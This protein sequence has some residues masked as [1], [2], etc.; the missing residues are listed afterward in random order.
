MESLEGEDISLSSYSSTSGLTMK[1]RFVDKNS[2]PI[3]DNTATMH[4]RG[5]TDPIKL[6]TY[7]RQNNSGVAAAIDVAAGQMNIDGTISAGNSHGLLVGDTVIG[8]I[9]A[10]GETTSG[11]TV[12]TLSDTTSGT[13][14]NAGV[15]YYV[16]SVDSE[17]GDFKLATGSVT[18]SS[19]TL[20]PGGTET[21]NS[22]ALRFRQVKLIDSGRFGGLLNLE[23][24]SSFQSVVTGGATNTATADPLVEGL[25]K[26]TTT[27][28]GEKQTLN[29]KINE[30]IDFNAGDTLGQAA[31]AAAATY[32][33]D[34]NFVDASLTSAG[35]A[36]SASVKS[37]NLQEQTKSALTKAV[38]NSLRSNAPISSIKGVTVSS[39]PADGSSL[40]VFFNGQN[41]VLTMVK[42]EVVVTGGELD[43]VSAYFEAVTSGYSLKVA[44]PDG[45]LTG[46]QFSVPTTVSGNTDAAT[47]FGMTPATVTKTLIGRSIAFTAGTAKTPIPIEVNGAAENITV[48]TTAANTFNTGGGSI[49]F[50]WVDDGGGKGHLKVTITGDSK[51]LKF[52]SNSKAEEVGIKTADILVYVKGE[53]LELETTDGQ[54]LDVDDSG[55][56]PMSS[57]A[58]ENFTLT[59]L[60]PEELIVVVSGGGAR[61]IAA[62]FDSNPPELEEITPEL[63]IKVTNDAGNVIDIVDKITG[64]SIATRQLDTAGAAEA[65]GFLFKIDGRAVQGDLYNFSANSGGVGD[66][67]NISAVLELQREKNG[68]GG[69][70]QV[71]S[72]IVSKVGSQV[73]SGKLNV[74]AAEAMREASEEAEAQFSGVNLDSQAAALI[75]FQQAY[76][77]SSR[78]LQTARELFQTLIE[79]V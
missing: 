2:K 67:R 14:N 18:G 11:L 55:S 61:K 53:D 71:F 27:S 62:N 34:V 9:I 59:N 10:G 76:Q 46:A 51:D 63:T 24:A 16:K 30:Q 49:V 20:T 57:L 41:Y 31:S 75:E 74:E 56:S 45:V 25:V 19:V 36:F 28:T 50:L 78:I 37:A 79:V 65:L 38:A 21:A 7:L 26:Q 22:H 73:K 64:H 8:R 66:N 35:T 44:A 77:A 52:K 3:G 68:K 43:R 33:I 4:A 32:G 39:V 40:T 72:N 23:S 58:K 13:L 5:N 70:Q 12:S 54:V 29:F 1:T 60:P 69:F 6:G 42:G 15:I 47:L 17:T 48:T